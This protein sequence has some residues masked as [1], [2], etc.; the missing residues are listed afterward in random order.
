[1]VKATA[2]LNL[3]LSLVVLPR[4]KQFIFLHRDCVLSSLECN[5]A[6]IPGDL[7]C[8]FY[9]HKQKHYCQILQ[10]LP[11]E[12]LS[13]DCTQLLPGYFFIPFAFIA[14]LRLFASLQ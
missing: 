8:L 12:G 10:L 9:W 3:Y 1:M 7:N 5:S 11:S 4:K 2:P 6:F 14:N 13:S